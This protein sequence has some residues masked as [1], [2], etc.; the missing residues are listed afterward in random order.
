M[1][2]EAPSLGLKLPGAH[3]DGVGPVVLEEQNLP[4]G[5]I[6][7]EDDAAGQ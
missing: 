4:E 1:Q 3:M 6:V 5:Q 2:V 7:G